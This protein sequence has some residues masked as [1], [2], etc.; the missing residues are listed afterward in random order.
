MGTPREIYRQPANRFVARFVGDANLLTGV[1][2]SGSD[3]RP[4]LKINDRCSL[5]MN[6]T[7]AAAARREGMVTC[8]VRPE[9]AAVSRAGGN[10]ALPGRI[11]DVVFLGKSTVYHVDVG[12]KTEFVV[13]VH[14]GESDPDRFAVGDTVHVRIPAECLS[15]IPD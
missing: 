10:G 9:F 14:G 12:L 3:Q 6:D 2:V 5:A 4:Q 13:R 8:L 7:R 15:V 1:L 11:A